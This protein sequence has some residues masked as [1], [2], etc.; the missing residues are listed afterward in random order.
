MSH[1]CVLVH[2]AWHNVKPATS[3]FPLKSQPCVLE[4]EAPAEGDS[5]SR[6]K[7]DEVF[8]KFD[9]QEVKKQEAR[10]GSPTDKLSG[11]SG[12]PLQSQ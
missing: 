9:W 1:T 4:S 5:T 2:V 8:H 11:L 3:S 7:L 6:D 10:S 12:K